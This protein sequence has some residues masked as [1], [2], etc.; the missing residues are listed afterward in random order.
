MFAA[1]FPLA[2]RSPEACVGKEKSFLPTQVCQEGRAD[3]AMRACK[4]GQNILLP[5]PV[6]PASFADLA[7]VDTEVPGRDGGHFASILQLPRHCSSPPPPLL[8]R[9]PRICTVLDWRNFCNVFARLGP[10]LSQCDQESEQP[11]AGVSDRHTARLRASPGDFCEHL[12]CF[13]ITSHIFS[14]C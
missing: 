13:S 4:F 5:P 1:Q 3:R 9:E 14:V 11:G 10:R 6:F 8:A 7:E 2:L 12:S